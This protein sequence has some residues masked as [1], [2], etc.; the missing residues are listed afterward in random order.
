MNYLTNVNDDSIN[1]PIIISTGENLFS[2]SNR[3]NRNGTNLNQILLYFSRHII[4]YFTF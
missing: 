3:E 1:Q 2:T 4:N